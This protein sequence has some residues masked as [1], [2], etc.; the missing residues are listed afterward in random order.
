MQSN[1]LLLSAI[2]RGVWAIEPNTL[3]ELL[4]TAENALAG[5]GLAW[6]HSEPA[7]TND[8]RRKTDQPQAEAGQVYAAVGSNSNVAHTFQMGYYTDLDSLPPGSICIIALQGIIMKS[9]FCGGGSM[10]RAERILQAG[11]HPNVAGILIDADTP[12]G[13]ANGLNTVHDAITLVRQRY[14]KPVLLVV[15]D[16]MLAS[17]GYHTASACTEVWATH[18]TCTIGS[19]GA[20]TQLRDTTARDEAEGIKNLVVYATRST[21]KNATAREALAGNAKGLI[22]ELDLLNDDFLARVQAGR[23]QLSGSAAKLDGEMFGAEQALAEGL[24]DTIGSYTQALERVLELANDP[25]FG[26]TTAGTPDDED[27]EDEAEE[28]EDAQEE[29]ADELPPFARPNYSHNP[30]SHNNPIMKYAALCAALGY[31][32]LVTTKEGAHFNTDALDQ[33]DTLLAQGALT[34]ASL[35]T[36]TASLS[37]AQAELATKATELSTAGATIKDLEQKVL[38]NPA[39]NQPVKLTTDAGEAD[40][41]P[42]AELSEWEKLD[43]QMVLEAQA[44]RKEFG[45]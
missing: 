33:L 34:T 11:A 14:G 38:N 32:S 43:A 12:G 16:G 24:I 20:L 29:E 44:M 2:R 22:A 3:T 28:E 1:F 42:K 35:A 23:P 36:A 30:I 45:L 19:I 4:P 39:T 17:A 27:R 41:A 37:T 10:L 31:S 7:Q 13:Q 6:L 21:R 26:P 15:N 25:A 9:G 8:L 5:H 40:P 18:S